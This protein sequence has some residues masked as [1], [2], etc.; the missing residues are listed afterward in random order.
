MSEFERTARGGHCGASEDS[1][2]S[3]PSSVLRRSKESPLDSS[4]VEA[5][6]FSSPPDPEPTEDGYVRDVYWPELSFL[7]RMASRRPAEVVDVLL[8]LKD[9]NNAWVRRAVFEIGAK[10]SGKRRQTTST[11]LGGMEDDRIWLAD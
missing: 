10:S 11:A 6:A 4:A 9:S 3:T 1:D 8:G 2:S 5:G 7:S